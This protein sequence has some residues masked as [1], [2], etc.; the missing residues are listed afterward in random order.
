MWQHWSTPLEEARPG[1]R[2]SAEALLS[3]RQSLEPWDT[4]QRQSPPRQ[5]GEVQSYGPCGSTRAHLNKEV[6]SGAMGH[7]AAPKPT[8]TGRCG[9]PLQLTWQRVDACPV[10]CLDL[11]LVCGV[12]GLQGA[13]TYRLIIEFCLYFLP[14]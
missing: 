2:G 9:L 3:G 14:H 12:L 1:P 13:D 5:G 10:P 4:W 8:S 11:E 7:I 6:R